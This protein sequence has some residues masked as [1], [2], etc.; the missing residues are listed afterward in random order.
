MP[1]VSITR[2]RVRSWHLLPLFLFHALRSA[3]QAKRAIG[4]QSATLL[5]DDWRTY[6]TR[7]V[8]TDEPAMKR[9]MT[10]GSHRRAMPR[11]LELCDEASVGRW[12]QKSAVPPSWAEVHRRMQY[13]GRPSKLNHPSAAQT[14]YR[15]PAPRVR[16]FA[17]VPLK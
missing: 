1:V 10:A 13:E 5:Q 16:P 11:L 4:I 17:Q 14:A 3:W 8:W 2:L 7:S 12:T 15:I 6:W 9:F